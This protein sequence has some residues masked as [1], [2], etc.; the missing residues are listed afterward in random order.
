MKNSVVIMGYV[1]LAAYLIGMLVIGFLCRKKYTDTVS[2]FFAGGKKLG[3]W[4]FALTY[5][6]TYL[7]S[8]TFIGNTGTAYSGGMAYLFMPLAQVLSLPLGLIIFSHMLRKMSKTLDVVTIPAYIEKRFKSP[9]AGAIASVVIVLFFIPYLVG[10]VKAGSLSLGSLLGVPYKAGVL[11]VALISVLYLMFGGY[12]ARCYTDV[13]QGIMMFVGMTAVL[14][15]GFYIVGGPAEIAKGV[16][17]SDPALLET[18]G[19]KG[20]SALFLYSTVFAIAPWGLPTLVQTNFTIGNRRN[21]YTAAIVL[22]VWVAFVLCGSMII[23]NMGR[24]YFGNALAGNAD[25]VFPS[26]VMAWFPNALGALIIVAV[27]A[28]A[29][30]TIDGTLMNSGAAIGVDIYK[31][32]LKKDATDKT[33]IKV[34]NITM[35]VITAIVIIWAFNPPAM[36]LTLTSWAF[37]LIAGGLIV[38]VYVGLYWKRATNAGAVAAIIAGVLGTLLWYVTKSPLGIPPFVMGCVFSLLAMFIASKLSKPLPQEFID[39]LFAPVPDE[40]IYDAE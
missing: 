6:S 37:S 18:P 33:V 36:V 19:P 32:F 30:S 31:R 40:Q 38:P 34:T 29:M 26:L 11:M 17:A 9:V 23:G 15:A 2:G 12:M 21:V 8:S 10:I 3:P 28:A 1:I 7:S 27:I 39:E 4:V 20:W 25:K 35:F 22:S 16:A 13:I 14:I 5:G 24:A